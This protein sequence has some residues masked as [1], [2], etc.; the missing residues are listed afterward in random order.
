[1]R[2]K[3]NAPTS[4]RRKP[5]YGTGTRLAR[6]VVGLMERPYGWSFEAIQNELRIGERT[7]LR[8]LAAC[9]REVVDDRGR[10]LFEVVRRGSRRMLRFAESVPKIDA[11]PY[12][13]LYFYFALS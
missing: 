5:T 10:P 1:M 6:I 7:L 12:D 4:A 2:L 13:L 3:K 11:A 8:Y 9:R